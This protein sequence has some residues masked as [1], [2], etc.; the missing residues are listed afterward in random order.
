MASRSSSRSIGWLSISGSGRRPGDGVAVGICIPG[1]IWCPG[2]WEGL[3][4]IVGICIPGVITCAGLADGD[5]VGIC[6]PGVITC[7]GLADGDAAGI[8]MPG[9]ITCGL[10]E[11]EGLGLLALLVGVRRARLAVLFFLGA[12]FGFGFAAGI[13][14][15]S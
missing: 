3:G 6:I 11:G 15:M 8:C 13:L 4:D 2:L 14:L 5:A 10:G 12:L 9:V 1:V 7:G